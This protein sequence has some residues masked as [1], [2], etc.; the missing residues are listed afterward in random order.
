MYTIIFLL[1]NDGLVIIY[2]INEIR[3]Y[4]TSIFRLTTN[5]Q[6][7]HTHQPHVARHQERAGQVGAAHPAQRSLTHK[8]HDGRAETFRTSQTERQRG[9]VLRRVNR[10][11]GEKG[12][13][14]PDNLG[15]KILRTTNSDIDR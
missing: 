1:N 11:G 2:D 9:G 5:I 7:I 6:L 3:D 14:S 13:G 4:R 15:R 12:Q 10:V 8:Y